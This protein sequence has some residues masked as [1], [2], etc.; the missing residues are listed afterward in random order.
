MEDFVN[1]VIT[2]DDKLHEHLQGL[3]EEAVGELESPEALEGDFLSEQDGLV[4]FANV[5]GDTSKKKKQ[6]LI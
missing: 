4:L 3:V 1:F 5:L 2:H 6:L